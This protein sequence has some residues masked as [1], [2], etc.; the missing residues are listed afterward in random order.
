MLDSYPELLGSFWRV[1]INEE[2]GLYAGRRLMWSSA[3]QSWLR[4]HRDLPG[5]EASPPTETQA[6]PDDLDLTPIVH[7]A[8]EHFQR[9][10]CAH[11]GLPDLES[12]FVAPDIFGVLTRYC[13]QR[14]QPSIIEA[15]RGTG[16]MK[17][18]AFLRGCNVSQR[19]KRALLR[20]TP[21]AR[22][23]STARE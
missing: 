10:F 6:A 8:I 9:V 7:L 4:S 15:P 5:Y 22:R 20:T 17:H 19:A 11:C 21:T 1:V 13:V 3:H 23:S 16:Q 18:W 2:T 14:P 12:H